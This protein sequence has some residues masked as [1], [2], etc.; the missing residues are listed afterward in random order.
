MVFSHDSFGRQPGSGDPSRGPL[1]R[2]A[3]GRYPRRRGRRDT[4]GTSSHSPSGLGG[5]PLPTLDSGLDMRVRIEVLHCSLTGRSGDLGDPLAGISHSARYLSPLEQLDLSPRIKFIR[6]RRWHVPQR[7]REPASAH[8]RALP[9]GWTR[10]SWRIGPSQ[11]R[12][13]SHR[14]RVREPTQIDGRSRRTTGGQRAT[15]NCHPSDA[16][17]QSGIGCQPGGGT[18]PSEG[19][20]GPELELDGAV[21]RHVVLPPTVPQQPSA[22][23][24]PGLQGTTLGETH[25]SDRDASC[26]AWGPSEQG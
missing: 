19:G 2:S 9:F 15:Q 16:A 12:D 17:D 4:L 1:N 21:R 8:A 25:P 22:V 10:A 3:R 6:R 23:A 14:S 7:T 5:K 11:A 13:Q 24:C 20:G 18:K 26:G